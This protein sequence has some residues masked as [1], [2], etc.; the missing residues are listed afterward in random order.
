MLLVGAL[1][2]LLAAPQAALADEAR[3][4]GYVLSFRLGVEPE[5]AKLL[6]DELARAT[7]DWHGQEARQGE[8]VKKSCAKSSDCVRKAAKALGVSRLGIVAIVSAGGVT[9]LDVRL[10]DANTGRELQRT[11][12]EYESTNGTDAAERAVFDLIPRLLPGEKAAPIAVIPPTPPKEDPLAPKVPPV[13]QIPQE[14]VTNTIDLES[15]SPKNNSETRWWL[16]GGIGAAATV[17]AVAAVF[18]LRDDNAGV[19]VLELPPPQ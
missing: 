18:I 4:V 3:G 15:T 16:W 10:M 2:A 9:R 6:V 1:L 11:H 5:P 13:S 14:P 8:A 19:P 12:A 7:S 17:T